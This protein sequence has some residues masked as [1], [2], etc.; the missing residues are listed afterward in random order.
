MEVKVLAK[1]I[2]FNTSFIDLKFSQKNEEIK[3]LNEEV[4]KLREELEYY[5]LKSY[6]KSFSPREKK[7]PLKNGD[8]NHE[9]MDK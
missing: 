6:E 8:K 2:D 7:H 3:L 4:K 1:E 5:K 9:E